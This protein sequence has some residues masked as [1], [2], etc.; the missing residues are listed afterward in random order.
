MVNTELDGG[1]FE[2]RSILKDSILKFEVL[3]TSALSGY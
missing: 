2:F 1:I 3:E